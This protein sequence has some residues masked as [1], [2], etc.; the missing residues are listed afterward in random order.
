LS[1]EY[2]ILKTEQAVLSQEEEALMANNSDWLPGRRELQLTMAQN[3][4]TVLQNQGGS[5]PWNIP[6]PTIADFQTQVGDTEII[7]KEAQSSTR[8][9][10]ITA[11]CKAA[12]DALTVK[13]R[14]LK[15]HYFLT[16]PLTDADYI[17]L[18]LQ[19][20]D[21]TH[22]PVPPPTAQAEADITH[23][24][25]HLLELHLRPVSGSPPDPHRSDYGY[26]IYYGVLP[27]RRRNGRSRHRNQT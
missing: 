19:P 11:E 22:T 24:G 10:V 2:G 9:P 18:E 1:T 14:F 17:A 13:M 5:N 20:R 25:V 6:Q 26:R 12:F 16:P 7:F 27:P 15:S 8:T 21:T 3:W 4:L 23:P